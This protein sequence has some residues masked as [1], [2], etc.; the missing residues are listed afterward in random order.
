MRRVEGTAE[1]RLQ[2]HEGGGADLLAA[3]RRRENT[4]R[5]PPMKEVSELLN[6]H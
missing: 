2:P 4:E 1:S 6:Q 3:S 5:P